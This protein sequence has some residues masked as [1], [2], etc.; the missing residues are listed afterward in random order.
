MKLNK[1]LFAFI[2]AGALVLAALVTVICISV[3]KPSSKTLYVGLYELTEAEKTAIHDVLESLNQE[4]EKPYEI[5]YTDFSDEKTLA[6]QV[7]L[8][9]SRA[10]D[11]VFTHSGVEADT[12]VQSIPTKKRKTTWYAKNATELYTSSFKTKALKN[13]DETIVQLPLLADFCEI[14]IDRSILR[15][16]GLS[17]INSWD[18]I[19]AFARK[20]KSFCDSPIIFAGRDDDTLINVLGT[21][22]ESMNSVQAYREVEDALLEVV[23]E[24]PAS[25]EQA[26]GQVL[27]ANATDPSSP[28]Y[29]AVHSLVRWYNAD[30]VHPEL[31]NLTKKD[32]SSLIDFGSAAVVLT[33]LSE[34]R[35]V[36]LKSIGRYSSI[37]YPSDMRPEMRAFL[38]DVLIAVPLSSNADK[39][40]FVAQ[41][42][43]SEWQERLCGISGLAPADA[44]C[45]VPDVQSDNVRYWIAATNTP[46]VP[47]SNSVCSNNTIK[48]ALARAIRAYIRELI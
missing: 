44:S 35:L 43:Q 19:E 2:I 29:V 22:T 14:D 37:Y 42:S 40:A 5:V 47:L 30:L 34:H 23:K 25:L 20:A 33:T 24:N 13:P 41:L 11:V 45:K 16:T 15:V 3:F 27:R 8:K 28:L 21:L 10:Q 32:V 26:F 39:N 1:K 46:L 6:S 9:G 38:S 17:T 18:D 12:L 4:R 36:P 31:L 48:A 7:V